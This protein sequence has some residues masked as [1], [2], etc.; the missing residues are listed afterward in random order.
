M[1]QKTYSKKLKESVFKRLAPPNAEKV[2]DLAKELNIPVNTLYTWRAKVLKESSPTSKKSRKWTSKDKFQ[3][4]LETASLSELETSKY[5]REKGIHV[6]ELKNWVKQCQN[7]NDTSFEDPKE[8]KDSLKNKQHKIKK[9]QKE[10]RHKE[11]ALAETAALLVLR[12]KAD[13]IWGDHEE[14]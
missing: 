3:A 1:P 8:L 12:K 9:L 4:V 7:A 13:A 2:P 14:E 6:E 5:C 10:L 11:K